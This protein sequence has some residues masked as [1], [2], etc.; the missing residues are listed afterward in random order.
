MCVC[1]VYARTAG[2][3]TRRNENKTAYGRLRRDGGAQEG[4][5]GDALPLRPCLIAL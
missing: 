4:L 5:D 2:M 3:E 1:D